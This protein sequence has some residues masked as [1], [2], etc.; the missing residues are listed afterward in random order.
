MLVS[1]A[2]AQ[3]NPQQAKQE[4]AEAK[5]RAKE[6]K[7]AMRAAEAALDAERQER[8]ARRCYDL[9]NIPLGELTTAQ[10]S[11]IGSCRYLGLL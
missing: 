2:S 9:S 11:S 4:K 1:S 10:Q 3:T 7:K 5:A 8:I 6:L